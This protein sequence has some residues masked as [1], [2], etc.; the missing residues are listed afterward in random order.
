[1]GTGTP[2]AR[3]YVSYT[4][5]TTTNSK[6]RDHI[7]AHSE[8][9]HETNRSTPRNETPIV[10]FTPLSSVF[11]IN[12]NTTI[13]LISN[14]PVN[15]L[16]ANEWSRLFWYRGVFFRFEQR[17]PSL[18]LLLLLFDSEPRRDSVSTP[19]SFYLRTTNSV[20]HNSISYNSDKVLTKQTDGSI[21]IGLI[22]IFDRW[23]A[24]TLVSV[25]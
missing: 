18:Q 10:T 19:P 5:N 4:F 12:S 17:Q 11:H 22:V 6:R 24:A 20:A 1:M 15:L 9:A 13:S 14:P 8:A 7:V 16:S 21:R 3:I 25:T 2:S 23:D